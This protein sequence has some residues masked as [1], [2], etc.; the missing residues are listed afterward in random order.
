MFNFMLNQFSPVCSF[1][2]FTDHCWAYRLG[3]DIP[4]MLMEDG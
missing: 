1:Y 3:L 4:N 2:E